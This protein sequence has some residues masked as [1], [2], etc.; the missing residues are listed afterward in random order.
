MEKELAERIRLYAVK[1]GFAACG[2]TTAED[3]PEYST[4]LSG[5]IREFPETEHLYEPMHKR[6]RIRKRFPWARS[7]I[8]CIRRYGKYKIPV[9]VKGH[10]GRN[11]LFDCRIPENPDHVMLKDFREFLKASGM[12]VRK[13]G[14]P[15]R[16][17]AQRAGVAAAGKNT[18]A[19]SGVCGSW[20]N[21]VTYLVDAKLEPDNPSKPTSPCPPDCR[22]CIEAC[23]TG[24][25]VRPYVMR[26]DRCIAYLTY[27]APLPLDPEL[28]KKMTGWLYGCDICQEVCPLNASAW[29]EKERL[30]YLEKISGLL[31]PQALSVMDVQTYRDVVHPLFYY[32]P[33]EDIG[34]W[35]A[36]ARRVLSSM[37]AMP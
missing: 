28:E 20:M 12:K 15:D 36:N 2:I 1:S 31:T 22:K 14:V 6:A 30:P 23:P 32:I 34:R 19:Y 27:G 26:M 16:L 33:T 3:F 18:F 24:A 37:A 11:Y 4:A 21:I 29:E 8:V 10:I 35:H 9:S 17:A 7:I 25:I 5:L 13:G